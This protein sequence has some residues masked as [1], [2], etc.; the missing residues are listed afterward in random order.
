MP[1]S[2][3][4]AKRLPNGVAVR[5]AALGQGTGAIGRAAAS[6]KDEIAAARF[7]ARSNAACA[8]EMDPRGFWQG[9]AGGGRAA[10]NIALSGV[11]KTGQDVYQITVGGASDALALTIGPSV[12]V[13]RGVD[14][15]E[16]IIQ[17]YVRVR[18]EGGRFI[19]ICRRPGAAPLREVFMRTID[20][21]RAARDLGVPDAGR[22]AYARRRAGHFDGS[23]PV[24]GS[25]AALIPGE[26]C[27]LDRRIIP[28][29][30]YDPDGAGYCAGY[31]GP[32]HYPRPDVFG[33]TADGRPRR[34]VTF[35][36]QNTRMTEILEPA[37]DLTRTREGEMSCLG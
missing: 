1:K 31:H 26:S 33:M 32:G 6:G 27:V 2:I 20:R 21:A 23:I 35:S 34:P 4:T 17:V 13:E 28:C 37:V 22:G 8:G 9:L 24:P 14:T 18:A 29:G 3:I 36:E 11:D 7:A 16:A 30:K 19:H 25:E 12:P 5:G 10:G 15:V